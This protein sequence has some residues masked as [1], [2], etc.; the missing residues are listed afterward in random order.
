VPTAGPLSH[1]PSENVILALMDAENHETVVT[2]SCPASHE[3]QTTATDAGMARPL[4]GHPPDE[5]YS[6]VV[7]GTDTCPTC[8]LRGY[9]KK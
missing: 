1:L 5:G 7:Y 8:G 3:W 2:L 9:L 6:P 4:V